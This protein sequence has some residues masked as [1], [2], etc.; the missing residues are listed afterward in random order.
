MK[1]AFSRRAFAL[2]L[3]TPLIAAR[4]PAHAQGA[5]APDQTSIEDFVRGLQKALRDNDAR[6]IA[7]RIKYPARYLAGKTKDVI[8][9][10]AS[11]ITGYKT[12][13]GPALRA[14]V[15]DQNPED[16][17]NNWQGYMIGGGSP[18][19]WA[20]LEGEGDKARLLIVTINNSK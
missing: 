2:L 9:T 12:Y 6:W 17:F 15:L 11:F 3:T 16:V 4:A 1:H 13:V 18:N 8:R 5:P 19:I 7:A 10:P 20:R 14:A